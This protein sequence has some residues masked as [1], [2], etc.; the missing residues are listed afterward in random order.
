MMTPIT[1]RS[2]IVSVLLHLSAMTVVCCSVALNTA[3]SQERP[4]KGK[5]PP[6]TPALARKGRATIVIDG[7]WQFAT[8]SDRQGKESGWF[9]AKP[10]AATDTS[11][12]AL[13][14]SSAAPGYTGTAWYWRAFAVPADWKG[15][16]VRIVFNAVAETAS[17]WLNGEALGDHTGGATPFEFNVTKSIK[18]GQNNLL[19]VRVDG[20][21]KR[22]AGIWQGVQVVSHDEA[23][24]QQVFVAADAFG[25]ISA[26][27][28]LLNT[29]TV[30]G[31]AELDCVVSTVT[32]K[33]PEVRKSNQ[34]LHLTPNLNVTNFI[35][36]IGKKDLTR[37]A[38]DSPFIYAYEL[39]FRQA[40]DILD[41]EDVHF[42]CRSFGMKDDQITLNGAP[43]SLVAMAPRIELPV[44]IAT[45]D[46]TDKMRA[47]L[48]KAKA[49]GVTILYLDAPNPATLE[50]AD[51]LGLLIIEGSRP[52]LTRAQGEAEMRSL[53]LRDRNHPSILGWNVGDCTADYARELRQLD[54]TRF[55]LTGVGSNISLWAPRKD[56]P[57]SGALPTG[58]MPLSR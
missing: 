58:L 36:S 17:V 11:I 47:L 35:T 20:D 10:A 46:D 53:V 50:L 27:I 13:W 6:T 3:S 40:K 30:E 5:P 14:S 23:Y 41:T 7:T 54:E 51:S 31:D 44:V 24:I 4:R 25:S 19:A 34:N 56:A 1:S 32:G 15:Q 33:K 16:T 28:S 22:G 52:G 21:V 2:W 39:I 57:E 18:I 43:L 42:G 38:L 29:S 55:L 8:D 45:T 37:W 26:D 48:T 12:P 49:A 9:R